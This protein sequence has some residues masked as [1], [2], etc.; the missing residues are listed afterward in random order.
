VYNWDR[1]YM[2]SFLMSL[3]HFT[4]AFARAAHEV[5]WSSEQYQAA[6]KQRMERTSSA[7]RSQ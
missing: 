1:I 3:M 5:A 4:K 2:A 7:F 6:N